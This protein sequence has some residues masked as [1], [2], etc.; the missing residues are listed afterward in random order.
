MWSVV[1]PGQKCARSVA[2]C[3]AKVWPSAMGRHVESAGGSRLWMVAE[4]ERERRSGTPCTWSW[5]Q[6]ESSAVEME[7][8]SAARTEVREVRQAGLPWP[9]SMRMRVGPVPT[10]YVFVPG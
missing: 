1:W 2:P 7:M 6:W 9:V 4:G 3:T 5:C 8:F 10:M